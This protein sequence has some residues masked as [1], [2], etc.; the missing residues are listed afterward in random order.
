LRKETHHHRPNPPETIWHLTP[1]GE[2]LR[3]RIQAEARVI[4]LADREAQG[5]VLCP[6]WVLR[7][8]AYWFRGLKG[9]KGRDVL[10]ALE[11]ALK[12]AKGADRD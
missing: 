12:T 3:A 6:V 9:P 2:A 8:A 11:T 4:E 1:E 5:E 10:L 7:E